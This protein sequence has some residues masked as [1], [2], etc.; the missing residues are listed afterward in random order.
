M[1]A[2]E[3]GTEF[4]VSL[5]KNRCYKT[6][7]NNPNPIIL[8]VLYLKVE[9]FAQSQWEILYCLHTK[10]PVGMFSTQTSA[11][12][13]GA[14]WTRLCPWDKDRRGWCFRVWDKMV[15][16]HLFWQV[17]G[18]CLRAAVG[19]NKRGQRMC[20]VWSPDTSLAYLQCLGSGCGSCRRFSS[21]VCIAAGVSVSSSH[22]FS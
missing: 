6:E 20:W 8:L 22:L 3:E 12:I 15:P 19:E 1:L 10:L 21:D 4:K 5:L 7:K 13:V 17:F 9:S 14:S 2:I 11:S 16:G 18:C